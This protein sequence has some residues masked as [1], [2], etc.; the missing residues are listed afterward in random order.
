MAAEI[1]DRPAHR[2]AWVAFASGLEVFNISVVYTIFI[3]YFVTVVAPDKVQGQAIWG[4]AA[5]VGGLM[6][7]LLAPPLGFLAE[8]PGVR[9]GLLLLMMALN[10]I[11]A[12]YFWQAAPGVGGMTLVILLLA[13]AVTMA[14]NDINYMLLGS[15]LP[16]IA[17]S[18]IMGRT[19]AAA[20]SIGWPVALAVTVAMMAVFIWGDPLHIGLDK[21]A[22]ERERIIGP[23]ACVIMLLMCAPLTLLAAPPRLAAP[24][25]R[26]LAQWLREE[27]GSL[28][29]ERAVALAVLSRIFYWSGLVLVQLFG[30]S[31]TRSVFDWN[32]EATTAFGL[33]T[34]TCGALGALAG[35]V[36]DD[37]LGSRNALVVTL[38][39]MA[40]SMAT[41]L[42]IHPDSVL[43]VI[44]LPARAADAGMLSSPAEWV[45]IGLGGLTG[46][47]IGPVGPITRTIVARLA[48]PGRSARYFGISAL[49]GN[50][51]NVIGPFIVAVLTQVSGDQRIGLI[52]APLLMLLGA[53][54]LLAVPPAKEAREA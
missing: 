3:P 52:A 49:A 24:P 21:A 11:P 43:F 8:R 44:A 9:R 42:T 48:P 18:R 14:A 19:S 26:D 34:L 2:R 35:G 50:S 25:K 46:F 37:W 5:G 28:L 36:L 20:V 4:Y 33:A 17:P 41:L 22:G 51:T 10:A 32:T 23:V 30:A 40:A 54:V 7:A 53:V 38:V 47:F 13:M 15:Y 45:A 6:G 16:D 29:A 1:N 12:L 31:L 27:I 39:G